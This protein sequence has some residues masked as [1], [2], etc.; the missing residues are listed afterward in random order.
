MKA[1]RSV[2]A[3]MTVADRGLSREVAA[4]GRVVIGGDLV[5][6]DL[7]G[8]GVIN[9]GLVE[10]PVDLIRIVVDLVVTRDFAGRGLVVAAVVRKS[11]ATITEIAHRVRPSSPVKLW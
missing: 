2:N 4:E 1:N 6:V 5:P 10:G 11:V 3:G 7:A 9:E 8:R